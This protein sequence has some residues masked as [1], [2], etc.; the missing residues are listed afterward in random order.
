MDSNSRALVA[1][2][3]ARWLSM[4]CY[5]VERRLYTRFSPNSLKLEEAQRTLAAAVCHE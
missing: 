2:D 3:K 4:G 1:G 5:S